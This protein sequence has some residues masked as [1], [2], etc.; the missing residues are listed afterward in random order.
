MAVD[1]IFIT[2]LRT[3]AA[4]LSVAN[5]NRDG[6]GTVATVFTA[7]ASGSK[8][9]KI[10]VKFT[11]SNTTGMIRLFL[12]DGSTYYL[13]QELTVDATITA[14]ATVAAFYKEITPDLILETGWSL[15]ASTEKAES[16]NIVITG[17]DY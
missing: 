13:W 16:S 10:S 9:I 7:G 6:T 4:N 12:H 2:S 15:R 8:V 1:P 11:V 3:E 14:S 5:P 17:G